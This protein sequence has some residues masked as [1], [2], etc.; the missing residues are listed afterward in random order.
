MKTVRIAL[1]ALCLASA[2]R[3]QATTPD[4]KG[5]VKQGQY[6]VQTVQL[7]HLTSAEAEH[8]LEPYVQNPGGGVFGV[9]NVRAVTIKEMPE[10]FMQMRQVLDRYDRDPTT[11]TLH[12]QL[13]AADNSGR[14]DP[15]VAG[16]DSLLRGVLKYSG[17]RLLSNAVVNVMER[18]TAQQSLSGEGDDYVL[19]YQVQDVTTDN[20]SGSVAIRVSLQKSGNFSVNGSVQHD[21]TLLS[22]GV[23]IP[24]GNTVV[25]GTSVE[26][27]KARP[28]IVVDGVKQADTGDKALILTVR[29]Q[30]A[31]KKDGK[32]PD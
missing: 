24:I 5:A 4:T 14:R 15:N 32:T 10:P 20:G 26:S 21:P 22:T 9:P 1:A 11:L 25:L 17:Y 30:F 19:Y 3:A 8:L 6:I 29:P 16:V 31:S 7:R 28:I 23:T 12:F 13:I 18:S 2:M 27:G